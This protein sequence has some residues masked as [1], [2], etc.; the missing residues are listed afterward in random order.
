MAA[1]ASMVA[2]ETRAYAKRADGT[3]V[4]AF[5]CRQKDGTIAVRLQRKMS[6][7]SDATRSAGA[8]VDVTDD[9][10]V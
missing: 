4:N 7:T 10:A 5:A 1:F 9:A 6:S 3:W 8:W 2:A